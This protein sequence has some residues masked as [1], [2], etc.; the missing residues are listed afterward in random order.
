MNN[1]NLQQE[2]DLFNEVVD[3]GTTYYS[4]IL[5]DG[6]ERVAYTFADENS[7]GEINTYCEYCGTN[8]GVDFD[9]ILMWRKIDDPTDLETAAKNYTRKLKHIESRDNAEKTYA[10]GYE[11]ALSHMFEAFKAGVG[12]QQ[13]RKGCDHIE[14]GTPEWWKKEF[15]EGAFLRG[16]FE[17]YLKRSGLWKGDWSEVTATRFRYRSNVWC[18][19]YD[20]LDGDFVE[21]FIEKIDDTI[22]SECVL[23]RDFLKWREKIKDRKE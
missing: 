9:D 12:W 7:D 11:D 21:V 16:I 23:F 5:K 4:V 14:A 18:S 15:E 22:I 2:K 6:S 19:K 17:T 3:W 10:Q 1:W 13:C 8:E 20:K